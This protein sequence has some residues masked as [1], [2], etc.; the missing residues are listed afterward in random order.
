MG[1]AGADTGVTC[2]NWA[3][4][5]GSPC[6]MPSARATGAVRVEIRAGTGSPCVMPSARVVGA[7][8]MEIRAEASFE[9]RLLAVI[10]IDRDAVVL[11]GSLC[12]SHDERR[13]GGEERENPVATHRF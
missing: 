11:G 12:L 4:G 3:R 1:L 5:T 7:V 8:R 13:E 9:A 6:V 10:R 2:K